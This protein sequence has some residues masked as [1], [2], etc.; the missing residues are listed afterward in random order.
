MDCQESKKRALEVTPEESFTPS[1]TRTPLDDI[2]FKDEIENLPEEAQ[3]ICLM[4]LNSPN[5]YLEL[6]T[7]EIHGVLRTQLREM[8]WTWSK[9]WSG[10]REIK[11]FLST[12][13]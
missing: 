13:H 9:I 6:A 4:I 10:F 7:R 5:E 11:K 1:T 3:T 12:S 2:L 8:G